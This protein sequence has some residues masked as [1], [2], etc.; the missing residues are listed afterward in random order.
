MDR[1]SL[2]FHRPYHV[3]IE[4][5]TLDAPGEGQVLVKTLFSSISAG[6]EMLIYRNKLEQGTLLDSVIP[7]L[8]RRFM[9][10]C[11]YGY[12]CV[13]TV[14]LVGRK[15][16][17]QWVGK[18]VFAFHPHESHFVISPADLIPIPLG[19][20]WKDALFLPN[21]ETAVN[22]VMDGAPARGERI[23]VFGQG[24]VGLLL[25]GLLAQKQGV[26]LVTIDKYPLRRTMSL[27][28]GAD[29]SLE[30][31][32]YVKGFFSNK[33]IGDD[34][35]ATLCFEVSG[36]PEALNDA[37]QTT[38][39]G[40]R[41]IIGSWY[42]TK[43]TSLDLGTHFHRNRLHLQSS[44][45][46]T[47]DPRFSAQWTRQRRINVALKMIQKLKPSR[48]ITH[49]YPLRRA[50]DAYALLDTRPENAIQV[51]FDYRG[52]HENV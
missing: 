9:Y 52:M 3:K 34:P 25:T 18:R 5:G 51:I 49:T 12:S 40:G 39:F 50:S 20:P 46:S 41:I 45:V 21:M 10:P 38:G 32:T 24:V 16:S 44:Q 28:L 35:G 7:T 26:T 42:G 8:S 23:V 22:L 47:I 33:N 2:L 48:L 29:E 13:G 14:V 36:E 19:M 11:T 15:V 37:I 4:K 1:F 43:R 6:T 17:P 31:H 30:R 27:K